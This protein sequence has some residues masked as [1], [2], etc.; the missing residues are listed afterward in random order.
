L[1][2]RPFRVADRA[3]ADEIATEA[4]RAVC[5]ALAS[6]SVGAASRFGASAVGAAVVALRAFCTYRAR[7]AVARRMGRN[8]EAAAA[9]EPGPARVGIVADLAH[10][11]AAVRLIGHD[12][13]V[14]RRV[15]GDGPVVA[16][17]PDCDRETDRH[18]DDATYGQA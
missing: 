11:G 9:C 17:C 4:A 14:E 18:A 7:R 12:R 5:V 13:R 3:E 15:V 6:A 1:V 2:G 8:A 10:A 16:A